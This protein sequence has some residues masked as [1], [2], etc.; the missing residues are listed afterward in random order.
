MINNKQNKYFLDELRLNSCYP[1]FR[2]V[3]NIATYVMFAAAFL[4]IFASIN[5]GTLFVGLVAAVLI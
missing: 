4:A 1:T 2:F 5:S 3:I